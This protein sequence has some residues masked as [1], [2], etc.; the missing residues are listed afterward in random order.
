M[1]RLILYLFFIAVI[2]GCKNGGRTDSGQ[3]PLQSEIPPIQ[4]ELFRQR[5]SV[6]ALLRGM[7][8]EKLD[9]SARAYWMIIQQGERMIPILLACLTE[10]SPTSVSDDCKKGKLNVGDVSYYAL[11]E[12]AEF[13]TY[14]IT[15]TQY[16]LFVNGCSGFHSYLFND[17]NKP[18]YQK[19][20]TDFYRTYRKTNFQFSKY[21][22][23]ELTICRKLYKIEGRLKWKEDQ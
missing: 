10:T 21:T 18:E 14:L 17:K 3:I 12:L 8:A 5:D 15:Q 23:K 19:K 22:A 11:E 16:D 13:P 1:K 4:Q 2:A 9:S 7:T 6:A 20:A